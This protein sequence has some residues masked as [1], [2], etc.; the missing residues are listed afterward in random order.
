MVAPNCDQH[1]LGQIASQFKEFL[2]L[3][4]EQGR[5]YFPGR[6]KN[7]GRIQTPNR[8]R[9]GTLSLESLAQAI[10]CCNKC[11]L[12]QQRT[13]GVPGQGNTKAWLMVV[14]EGPGYEEDRQGRPFVGPA[15]ELLTRMLKAI[16]LNREDVYITNVVKCRPPENRVPREDE[17]QSCFHFLTEEINSLHPKLL[18]A[19]GG[20]A[21][22]T[23]ARSKDRISQLRRENLSFEGISVKATYHPAFL[24]R[25]PEYKKEA[26]EDLKEVRRFYHGLAEKK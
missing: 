6:R 20:S 11:R 8:G 23:L 12:S 16:D 19:L 5:R 14:G 1:P 24:L 13:Q 7:A 10:G 3:R 18:L 15:G 22:Q 21:A 25:N 2:L 26:W 4:Q 17:V 9:E